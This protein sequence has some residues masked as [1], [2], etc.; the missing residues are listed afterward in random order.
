MKTGISIATALLEETDRAARKPGVSRSRLM[1]L[2]WRNYLRQSRNREIV[3][4]LNLVYAEQ[5]GL[6]DQ[7]SS[8]RMKTKLRSMVKNTW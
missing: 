4:Q 7:P 3:E 8:G 6:A 5:A 2:A 1:S